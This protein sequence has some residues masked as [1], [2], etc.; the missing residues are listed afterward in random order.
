L[1]LV[2]RLLERLSS[3][4]RLHF[5]ELVAQPIPDRPLLSTGLRKNLEFRQ[6]REGDPDIESMPARSEVK[7]SRFRQQAICLGV[8]QKGVLIGYGWFCFERYEEDEVRC[9]YVLPADGV[10]DFDVY[11]FPD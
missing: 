11:V 3:Q 5:Y 10:F 8:Y 4:F 1:Y 7:E 2:D 9:T 6:I